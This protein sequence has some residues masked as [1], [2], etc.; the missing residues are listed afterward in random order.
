[1]DNNIINQPTRQIGL[2]YVRVILML[3]IFNFHASMHGGVDYGWIDNFVSQGAVAMEGFFLL[4]GFCLARQ[5][6]QNVIDTGKEI[7]SFYYKRALRLLPLY[8][9]IWIIKRLGT[10]STISIQD[11]L[12]I[13]FELFGITSAFDGSFSVSQGDWFVS[14]MLLCYFLFPLLQMLIQKLSDRNMKCMLL[15][16]YVISSLAPV[17]ASICGFSRTYPN[18]FFRMLQF[19]MG[20]MLVSL[21][22][23]IEIKSYARIAI[24]TICFMMLVFVVSFLHARDWGSYGSYEFI[25]IPVW[26]IMIILLAYPF[27]SH[28]IVAKIVLHLSRISYAF[29]LMQVWCYGIALC[30]VSKIELHSLLL[31]HNSIVLC[32]S[33]LTCLIGAEVLTKVDNGISK[34]FKNNFL[35]NR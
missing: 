13:P 6:S 3:L 22:E 14:C 29:Y 5:Y 27:S 15:I 19:A 10:I 28:G 17:T 34:M 11:I 31:N 30:L 4:S 26:S 32:V 16:L 20:M 24:S 18:P 12:L 7:W 23:R 25:T 2:D 33:F 9:I 8:W 21:I 1:M 35:H